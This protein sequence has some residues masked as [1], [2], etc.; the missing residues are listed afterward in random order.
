[1]VEIFNQ[2]K[3]VSRLRREF[4]KKALGLFMGE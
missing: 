4:Y 2:A 3:D 1:M